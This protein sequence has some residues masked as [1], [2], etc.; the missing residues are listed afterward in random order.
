M[1]DE[2]RRAENALS[3]TE[4][5]Q[6][7]SNIFPQMSKEPEEPGD[8]P[9]KETAGGEGDRQ[10]DTGGGGQ[11][12]K[13][14]GD[15]GG[16][17]P[18]LAQQIADLTAKITRLETHNARINAALHEERAKR[19]TETPS[20]KETPAPAALPGEAD[21]VDPEI[22]ET[23]R[24]A[25]PELEEVKTLKDE[26]TSLRNQ[27]AEANER[28]ELERRTADFEASTTR[29]KGK[30]GQE[31]YDEVVNATEKFFDPD[32]PDYNPAFVSALQ[33]STDPGQYLYDL[34]VSVALPDRIERI[35]KEA[36]E[37]GR[38]E[39]Q[40]QL[41]GTKTVPNL[42]AHGKPPART[43]SELTQDQKDLAVVF[44]HSD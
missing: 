6:V 20:K 21:D 28:A 31:D 29:A 34:G 39:V 26:L 30:P 14:D 32:G 11:D 15:G 19:R 12:L 25:V 27:Q 2:T 44:G 4:E 13:P 41:R 18:D 23:I 8:Q 42:S 33:K 35:R 16:T 22:R 10:A 1:S 43:K 17:E 9:E 24:R 37:R 3:E 40:E 7:L 36:Y 38:K 5:A